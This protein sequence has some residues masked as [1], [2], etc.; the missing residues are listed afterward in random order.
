MALSILINGMGRIGREVVRQVAGSSI[1]IVAINDPYN[2]SLE[3]VAELINNDSFLWGK[4]KSKIASVSDTSL[5]VNGHDIPYYNFTKID[6]GNWDNLKGLGFTVIVDCTGIENDSK[7]NYAV[8]QDSTLKIF[9]LGIDSAISVAVTPENISKQ[10]WSSVYYCVPPAESIVAS[11][12]LYAT[13]DGGNNFDYVD[14][15]F[16][17]CYE[18]YDNSY[19]LMD[20]GLNNKFIYSASNN[21]FVK[22]NPGRPVGHIFPQLNG[23]IIGRTVHIPSMK[24]LGLCKIHLNSNEELDMSADNYTLGSDSFSHLANL[25][26]TKYLNTLGEVMNSTKGIGDLRVGQL[27]DTYHVE[28]CIYFNIDHV[29]V[30]NA[31][32]TITKYYAAI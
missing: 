12:A 6:A 8:I 17:E 16:I 20:Y 31:L 10:N 26:E 2:A 3:N 21:S 14:S 27:S 25:T 13:L 28:L 32:E 22:G 9:Y 19:S 30:S 5:S 15:C 4:N 29:L 7:Y 11:Q 1:N 18:G 24:N 23:K